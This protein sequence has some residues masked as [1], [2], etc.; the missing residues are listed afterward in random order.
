MKRKFCQY[1]YGFLGK[2]PGLRMVFLYIFVVLPTPAILHF[3]FGGG[4][5]LSAIYKAFGVIGIIFCPITFG[6][7]SNI[8]TGSIRLS[9]SL[10]G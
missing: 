5:H 1:T 8:G 4:I 3:F 7:T 2:H 9:Y 6:V 10:M